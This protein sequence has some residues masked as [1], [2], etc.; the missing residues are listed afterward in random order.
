MNISLYQET[1]LHKMFSMKVKWSLRRN[2]QY[3]S[4]LKI[5]Y[6]HIVRIPIRKVTHVFPKMCRKVQRHSNCFVSKAH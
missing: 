2:S 4:V 1:V 5:T 6:E 3:L